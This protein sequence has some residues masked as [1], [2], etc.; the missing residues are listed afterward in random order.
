MSK[1]VEHRLE[2]PES[3]PSGLDEF[4]Q[5]LS[6]LAALGLISGFIMHEIRNVMA[7]IS[8]NTQIIQI[9]GEKLGS[10]DT[11]HRLDQ[12]LEQIERIQNIL[13]RIGGFTA[14][15]QGEIV[16]V[17]PDR[18]VINSISALDRMF[19]NRGL[20]VTESL[21]ENEK[22]IL[23]D[24]SLFDFLLLQ[25]LETC[26]PKERSVGKIEVTS[27]SKAKKWEMK[28]ILRPEENEEDFY[29]NFIE[30]VSGFGLTAVLMALKAVKGELFL[31]SGPDDYGFRL[32]VPWEA[33]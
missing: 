13:N 10:Q 14:R 17:Q 5:K 20:K 4:T 31:L 23:C 1:Q 25:L 7:I 11:T 26:I 22:T 2:L 19:E 18:T 8:G 9:K 29:S 3:L 32:I 24:A 6:R 33:D 21:R 28:L 30:R 27:S 12:I 15:A 16:E